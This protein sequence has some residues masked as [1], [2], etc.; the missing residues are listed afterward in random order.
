[1]PQPCKHE[2]TFE[3]TDKDLKLHVSVC[4][5]CQTLRHS[6]F[7]PLPDGIEQ[8]MEEVRRWAQHYAK[9]AR[10]VSDGA[11]IAQKNEKVLVDLRKAMMQHRMVKNEALET[12]AEALEEKGMTDAAV[13]ARS[14]KL[15]VS[16]KEA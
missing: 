4:T 11:V 9:S 2:H 12:V 6:C 13:V 7:E 15:E 3:T 16:L 1:M 8:G 5:D 10:T 14:L